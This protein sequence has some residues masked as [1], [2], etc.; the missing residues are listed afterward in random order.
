MEGLV[1]VLGFGPAALLSNSLPSGEKTQAS[2]PP[3]CC[4]N[5]KS[6]FSPVTSHSTGAALQKPTSNLVRS[7][8]KTA[9][10]AWSALSSVATRAATFRLEMSKTSTRPC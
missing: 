9:K 1:S 7:G 6:A 2:P 8:E 4:S 3:G 10:D 5:A